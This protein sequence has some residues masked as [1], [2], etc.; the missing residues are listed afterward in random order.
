MNSDYLLPGIAAVAI[1]ALYPVYWISEI[2]LSVEL[3]AIRTSLQPLDALFLATGALAAYLYYSLKQILNDQSGYHGTDVILLVLVG[4]MLVSYPALLV[5]AITLPTESWLL[6]V[7]W[8]GALI[9]SG[10]LDIVLAV[11][12]LR[13]GEQIPRL[14][15]AFAVANL[16]MGF[17]ELTVIF[18]F[19]VIFIYPVCAIILA[20]QFLRKP[21]LVEIV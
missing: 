12:L 16:I 13:G 1:A 7:V 19:A 21:D 5:L 8:G 20:I 11:L 9:V 6:A 17:C 2:A 4:F 10:V 14:I 3:G 15:K 18:A